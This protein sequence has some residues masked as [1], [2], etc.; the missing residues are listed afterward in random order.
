MSKTDPAS[1]VPLESGT[2]TA[3][4]DVAPTNV[5]QNDDTANKKSAATMLVELAQDRFS[6][7]VSDLDE[8]F[9]LDKSGPKIVRTLRG[10]KTS[11]RSVLARLYFDAYKRTAGQQALSD[12]LLVLEG[13]CIDAP[14][15]QLHVRVGE[16][17]DDFWLDLGDNS[18][19][20]VRISS[21][22]WSVE[23]EPPVRF[24]R[25]SLQAAL[26]SPVAGGSLEVLWE[27]L[28]VDVKDRPLILSYLV[29]ALMPSIPHPILSLIAEQ[30]TGKSTATRV[31]V[32]ILDP[33]PVPLRKPPKDMDS[34]VTAAQGSWVV[35]LDNLSGLPDWL[36]DSLCRAATGDG[37]VRR[38]L[39]TDGDVTVFSFR[40]CVIANGIDLGAVRDD[41]TDR[42]LPVNLAVI[43]AA[44]RR[45][46]AGIWKRWADE[47]PRIL[48][49]LLDLAV[50]VL[51]CLPAIKLSESPRMADFARVVAA[52]DQ[53]L[54]QQGL[55]RYLNRASEMAVDQLAGDVFFERID[56]VITAEG[57]YTAADL[58]AAVKP[59]E[60]WKPEPRTGWPRNAREVTGRLRRMAPT[61]RKVGWTVID[62]GRGG[63]D[64]VTRFKIAPPSPAGNA[65]AGDPQERRRESHPQRPQR[66]QTTEFAGKAGDDGTN[67]AISPTPPA[68]AVARKP[69][70]HPGDPAAKCGTCAAERA[71]QRARDAATDLDCRY[72]GQPATRADG[73]CETAD[74][75]HISARRFDGC[76]RK[77]DAA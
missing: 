62:I 60:P 42:M 10:G 1:T 64:K 59:E 55:D 5:D 54:G 6:F 74:R 77:D 76:L 2:S 69:C 41:F 57:E 8:P 75:E 40:R 27:W 3:Q 71:N 31:L 49:A 35:G 24:K 33:S 18:G 11:L 56:V 61:M 21:G 37:D 23:Q 7:G 26:P 68:P 19:A 70:G 13:R 14:V 25:T 44:Q 53:V 16:H 51:R 15:T 48:G 66:P 50:E 72:C 36:S 58:L 65:A 22:G 4:A 17:R 63:H 43:P 32:S 9:A 47:H 73:Y 52:V 28:N 46:E 20:A 38:R 39:Y 45:S 29:A 67:P 30:G 12:A 34:W